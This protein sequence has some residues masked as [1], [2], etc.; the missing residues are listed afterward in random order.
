[1][2][3]KVIQILLQ[4][5]KHQTS[6]VLVLKALERSH[7]IEFVR[8]LL[9]ESRKDGHFDLALSRVRRMVLEDLDGDNVV[10][11]AFPALDDL[12]KCAAAEELKNL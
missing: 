8:I 7:E 9:A 11:A 4:H 5:L 6:V 12:A 1:M 10:G 2:L 3:Q